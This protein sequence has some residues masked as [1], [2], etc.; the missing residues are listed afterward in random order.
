[1]LNIKVLLD[2]R[3][4]AGLNRS[5]LFDKSFSPIGWQANG[6]LDFWL[7]ILRGATSAFAFAASL[8]LCRGDW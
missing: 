6:I 3:F 8:V 7:S 1:M 4:D 2:Q 5:I